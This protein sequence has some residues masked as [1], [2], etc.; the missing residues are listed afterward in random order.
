MSKFTSPAVC[1][2]IDTHELVAGVRVPRDPAVVAQ[3]LQRHLSELLSQ[4]YEVLGVQPLPTALLCIATLK[5]GVPV[6]FYGCEG[7]TC[8]P[9]RH[10]LQCPQLAL[11]DRQR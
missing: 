4:G 9:G 1:T 5:A 8:E 11:E 10:T 2:A 6:R 3:T 7:L